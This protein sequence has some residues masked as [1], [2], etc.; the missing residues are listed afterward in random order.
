MTWD[1]WGLGWEANLGAKIP[2]VSDTLTVGNLLEA[3]ITVS[4]MTL[5]VRWIRD[6]LRYKVL[7]ATDWDP[8]LR[9]TCHVVDV[10]D[11]GRRRPLRPRTDNCNSTRARS[12][13][14]SPRSVSAWVYGLQEIINN[15]VSGLILLVKRP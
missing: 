11:G 1:L 9:Y 13:G 7:P 8:G 14:S 12:V 2:F 10:R 5:V 3:A 6:A 15:F 4:V